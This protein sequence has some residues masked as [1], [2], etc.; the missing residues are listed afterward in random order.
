M[1]NEANGVDDLLE[2]Y[3][4][5]EENTEVPPVEGT[6]SA[7]ETPA[8]AEP[9]VG[10]AAPVVEEPNPAKAAGVAPNEEPPKVETPP[11]AS[12]DPRDEMIKQQD[13]TIK[14][15]QE[16]VEKISQQVAHGIPA[17]AVPEVKDAP[18]T[19]L[20]KEEDL[21]KALNSVDNFNAMLTGVISKAEEVIMA[22][23]QMLAVQIANDIYTKRTA[24]QEFYTANPDLASNKSYVGMVANELAAAHP[25]WDM[26]KV[27]ANLAN[28]VRTRL[29]L[30]VAAPQA[31]APVVETPPA[32]PAFATGR[33]SRGGGPAPTSDPV[34]KE[35][36]DLLDGI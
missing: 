19:F 36:A 22:K 6:P 17:P 14:S 34:A 8:T 7:E 35:V 21:D 26:Q 15:L 29:H 9:P 13:D 27:I 23:A 25:E 10:D 2:G 11:V 12:V 20:E 16:M 24:A 5:P 18:V 33:Q 31:G 1:G 3:I 4:P 32:S 28:E 30:G